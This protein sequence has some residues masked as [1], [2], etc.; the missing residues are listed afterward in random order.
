[1]IDKRDKARPAIVIPIEDP[2]ASPLL[3]SSLESALF[4]FLSP[5]SGFFYAACSLL[6]HL[7]LDRFS[8]DE[9]IA[10]PVRVSLLHRHLQPDRCFVNQ[11]IALSVRVSFLH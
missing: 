4:Y 7:Q 11:R 6:N 1:L 2:M 5:S 9:R 3:F 8:I 10:L